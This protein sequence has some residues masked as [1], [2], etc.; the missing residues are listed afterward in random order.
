MALRAA[1]AEWATWAC[2]CLRAGP[3]GPALRHVPARPRV[4]GALHFGGRKTHESRLLARALDTGPDRLPPARGEPVSPEILAGARA[5]TR[6]D[7]V[8]AVVRQD[9]RHAL[10]ARSGSSRP[11][12]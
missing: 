12:A 5:A 2:N 7:R 4:S 11:G 8:R 1:W 6:R 3:H 10:V 9:S